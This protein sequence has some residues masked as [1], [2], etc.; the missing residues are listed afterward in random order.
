MTT[1][2][3]ADLEVGTLVRVNLAENICAEPDYRFVTF[4]AS[5]YVVTEDGDM[6]YQLYLFDIPGWEAYDFFVTED[7]EITVSR[8]E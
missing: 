4:I 6:G 8:A 1:Q 7:C 3:P 2:Q 5:R